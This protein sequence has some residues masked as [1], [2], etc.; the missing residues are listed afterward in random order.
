MGWQIFK[1]EKYFPSF[2][3]F[4]WD[5]T[6][7][8]ATI[9]WLLEG[10]DETGVTDSLSMTWNDVFL[11]KFENFIFLPFAI[12]FVFIPTRPFLTNL[13]FDKHNIWRSLG[14][15]KHKKKTSSIIVLEGKY[16]YT[17]L[18]RKRRFISEEPSRKKHYLP[19]E[20]LFS[21]IPNSTRYRI[22]VLV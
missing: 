1:K 16:Y 22:P 4:F 13:F 11:G 8:W 21:W 19:Y 6:W 2:F 7:S 9:I 12:M 14:F 3:Y 10:L 20:T 17:D 15:G 18:V 5:P